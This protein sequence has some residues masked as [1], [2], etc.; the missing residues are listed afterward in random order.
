MP[1]S[2]GFLTGEAWSINQ[3]ALPL[4][5]HQQIMGLADIDVLANVRTVSKA[6]VVADQMLWNGDVRFYPS[7]DGVIG[8]PSLWIAEDFGCCASG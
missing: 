8:R 7:A 5:I 1:D 3:L 6:D 2:R 4:K